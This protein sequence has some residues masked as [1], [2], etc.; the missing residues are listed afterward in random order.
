MSPERRRR[1]VVVVQQ[2]LGVSERRACRV[3]NQ[4]L[5]TQRRK[6]K[7]KENEEALGQRP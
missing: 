7:V 3:L 6:S 1:C 5:S 2:Q 4:A